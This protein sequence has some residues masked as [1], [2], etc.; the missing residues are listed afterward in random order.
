MDKDIIETTKEITKRI[1]IIC[2]EILKFVGK[3]ILNVLGFIVGIIFWILGLIAFLIICYFMWRWAC[4]TADLT[5]ANALDF[6][7]GNT[8]SC[9]SSF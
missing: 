9:D 4:P 2:L 8:F 6:A 7:I 3:V 1:L 5:L